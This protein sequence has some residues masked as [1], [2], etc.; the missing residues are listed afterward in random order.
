[1]DHLVRVETRHWHWA[2]QLQVL[3][4]LRQQIAAP[5]T[6]LSAQSERIL[7]SMD[8]GMKPV[9]SHD[10]SDS[11]HFPNREILFVWF[12][13]VLV[14]RGT[15]NKL[16]ACVT[17]GDFRMPKTELTDYVRDASLSQ[18]ANWSSTRYL[19]FVAVQLRS[20][21]LCGTAPGHLDWSPLFRH[22][23]VSSVKVGYSS[24]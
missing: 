13:W 5:R 4:L 17:I 23:V 15:H 21:I 14:F 12:R 2:A 11:C 10:R 7:N 8:Q 22:R 9:W 19:S 18:R 24:P 3:P 20:P 1:V 6:N 16:L